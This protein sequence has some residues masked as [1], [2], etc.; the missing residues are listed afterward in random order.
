MTIQAWWSK[1]NEGKLDVNRKK[2]ITASVYVVWHILKERGRR[3]FQQKS[4]TAPRVAELVAADLMMLQMA[5]RIDNTIEN[6][7]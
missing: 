3:I 4:M 7:N 1:L 6:R 5:Y 2:G